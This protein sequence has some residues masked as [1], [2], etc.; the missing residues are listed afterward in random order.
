MISCTEFILAYSELF[1]YLDEHHGFG[2]VRDF[3][4]G[5]SDN[6]LTNLRRYVSREGT[7]GMRKYWT[8][9][10]TEER[11]DH[12]MTCEPDR[13]V[14]EMRRC[15]S[16]GLLRNAAWM[17]RYKRYCEHCDILYRRVVEDYGFDYNVSY[18]DPERG[19]C[20]VEIVKRQD[21]GPKRKRNPKSVRK[22]GVP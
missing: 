1:K 5:I 20:R 11:A 17:K 10:L 14:I 21:G 3:W 15:P 22:G 8:H 19:V 7:E 16:V 6:F 2:A 13:F 4:I 18:I 12:V 9:T